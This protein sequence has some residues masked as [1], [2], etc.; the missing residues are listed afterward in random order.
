M[1]QVDF[2]EGSIPSKITQTAIPMLVAQLLTLLY[3][4]VDRIYLGRIPG[5]GT[6]ALGGIGLCFPVILI[7]TAFTNMYGLGGS[8][9]FAIARGTKEKE[10]AGDILNTSFRL[11]LLTAILLLIL[12]EVFARPVLTAFGARG[13]AIRYSLP[14]LRVY[15]L[16]TPFAMLAT[17]LNPS[18]NAEGF[19][20][21]GMTTVAIGAISNLILDPVFIYGF[22]LGVVGAALATILS[23]AFSALLALRFLTGKNTKY[24]LQ[25]PFSSLTAPGRLP[26]AGNIISLGTAPFIMQFTNSLVQIA[27]NNTLME[28]G[29]AINVSIMTIVS[30]VRQIL[31][32]PISS[33]T[34]GSAPI[35]SYNYGARKFS[36]VWEAIRIMTILAVSYTLII[37]LL[38]EFRP[39]MFIA[40]FSKDAQIMELAIPDLH[41][42]F[43]AFIFQALQYSGQTVFKALNKKNHAIFFSLFRK[44]V[45]VVPLTL[46]LPRFF[47]LGVKGVFL[48]EPISNFIGGSACYLT[49]LYTL[50]KETRESK[51]S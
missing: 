34:D 10:K 50:R 49:M 14:Y 32:V 51:E 41:L 7:I 30:S 38:I 20:K 24:R 31:D 39:G 29:G 27:C 1:K 33:I 23:Q 19:P 45:M 15:L 8:P 42:Y 40:I 9:L 13:E 17:G 43:F 36:R 22:K 5:E 28:Y 44:V 18:I 25:N 12:G 4:I 3:S 26:Y 37:Q 48:A 47:G 46:L 6:A 35:V 16:G 2:G 11:L 21:I